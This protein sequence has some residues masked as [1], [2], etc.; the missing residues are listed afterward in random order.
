MSEL[1]EIKCKSCVSNKMVEEDGFLV[2]QNCGTK[3]TIPHS[4]KGVGKVVLNKVTPAKVQ[5]GSKAIFFIWL[6]IAG[7]MF[8]FIPWAVFAGVIGIFGMTLFEFL[9]LHILAAAMPVVGIAFWPSVLFIALVIA[10]SGAFKK[11]DKVE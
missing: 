2:C 1:I 5:G 9:G 8:V 11:S 7:P 4:F 3:H 6:M 10:I